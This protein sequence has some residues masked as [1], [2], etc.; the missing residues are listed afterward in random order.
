LTPPRNSVELSRAILHMLDHE[1]LR[2]QF[3]SRGLL[4]ARDYA[5]PRVAQ[6]IAEFYLQLLTTNEKGRI[7][8]ATAT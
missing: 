7:R 3:I 5:W 1:A 4:K 6:R 8:Y 2:R